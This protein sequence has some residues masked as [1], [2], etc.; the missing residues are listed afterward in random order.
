MRL[1]CLQNKPIDLIHL[2][3]QVIQELDPSFEV[4]GHAAA[5]GAMISET[6]LNDLIFR[7]NQLVQEKV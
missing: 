3:N 5:A 4:G 2:L 1:S 6:F 7:V